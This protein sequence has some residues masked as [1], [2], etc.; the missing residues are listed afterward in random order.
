MLDVALLIN[1]IVEKLQDIPELVAC[2]NHRP[3]QIFAYHDIYPSKANLFKAVA[4]M[5]PGQ[6][7]V[8]WA[9]CQPPPSTMGYWA[10][11]I[12]IFI[13]AAEEQPTARPDGYY[14][15]IRMIFD[16]VPRGGSCSMRQISFMPYLDPM[17]AESAVRM[18]DEQ[19]TDYFEVRFQLV[20]TVPV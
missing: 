1:S 4:T 17:T 13:R 14:R 5:T 9:G 12:Q 19:G 18:V 2:L 7:M 10:H 15:L 16:G 6:I 8:S 20:E 11:N 3:E